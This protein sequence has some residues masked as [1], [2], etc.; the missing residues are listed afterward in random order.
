[1]ATRPLVKAV[2]AHVFD[3]ARPQRADGLR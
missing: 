1:V 3:H 2:H